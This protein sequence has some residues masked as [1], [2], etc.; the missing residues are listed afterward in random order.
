MSDLSGYWR[1][2]LGTSRYLHRIC[3]HIWCRSEAE[4]DLQVLMKSRLDLLETQYECATA[5][6]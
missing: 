2:E 1:D 3:T 6:S 4:N 5:T